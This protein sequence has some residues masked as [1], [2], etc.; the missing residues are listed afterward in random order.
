MK[1][2]RDYVGKEDVWPDEEDEYLIPKNIM[3]KLCDCM[4]IPTVLHTPTLTKPTLRRERVQVVGHC[5][6]SP[7]DL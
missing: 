4:Y 5:Q 3:S 1:V 6:G 2:G 7:P